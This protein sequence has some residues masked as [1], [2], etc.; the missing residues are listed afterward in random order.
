MA[1]AEQHK[2]P[3]VPTHRRKRDDLPAMVLGVHDGNVLYRVQWFESGR[4]LENTLV[5]SA[6]RFAE[7]FA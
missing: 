2:R 3:F 1:S 4:S 7:L 5:R 6:A